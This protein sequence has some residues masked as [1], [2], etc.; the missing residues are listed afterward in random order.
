[1]WQHHFGR[2]L[3]P[4]MAN[5]GRSGAAPTHPELLDWLATEFVRS[6]WSQKAMHR[7]MVFSTAYRQSSEIDGAR[8][9]R[10]R[11]CPARLVAVAADRG[12]SCPRRDARGRRQV[13]SRMFGIPV[14]VS[15]QHDGS[16]ATA[17]DAQ[18]NRR[19][20]YLIVRR[21]Q[22]L[23]MLDLFD[24]PMMEINCPVRNESIVPLQALAMIN[25]P[26]AER[27]GKALGDRILREA[28]D[29]FTKQ[30]DYAYRLLYARSP[31]EKEAQRAGEFLR[32]DGRGAKWPAGASPAA[33][34]RPRPRPPGPRRRWYS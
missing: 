25:G 13:E 34:K 26:F 30:A 33:T 16:V 3:S 18:G 8:G 15:A 2:A 11:Q 31:S 7:L 12:G 14:P 32:C 23:T 6:G 24:T 5:F 19:S 28:G 9:G 4:T 20:V 21:S 22:H 10:P 1:M 29:D 17:D 27:C